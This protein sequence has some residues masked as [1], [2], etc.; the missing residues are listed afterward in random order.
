MGAC[1][2]RSWHTRAGVRTRLPIAYNDAKARTT[3]RQ[4][5]V[6]KQRLPWP[7]QLSRQAS[8]RSSPRR[9]GLVEMLEKATHQPPRMAFQIGRG[10]SQLAW[11]KKNPTPAV[12]KVGLQTNRNRF[13]PQQLLLLSDYAGNRQIASKLRPTYYAVVST[14]SDV[15]YTVCCVVRALRPSLPPISLPQSNQAYLNDWPICLSSSVCAVS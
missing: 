1:S 9:E 7:S 12:E 6:T 15:V 11:T 13:L 8:S 4:R 5:Y 3:E 2:L 10:R 14:T